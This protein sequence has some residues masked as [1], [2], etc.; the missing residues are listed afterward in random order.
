[1]YEAPLRRASEVAEAWLA[2][3]AN[4]PLRSLGRRGAADLVERCCRL[5]RLAAAGMAR[6][7][8][9][10]ILNDVVLNQVLLR[11]H[12]A[13][14]A[15]VIDRAQRDGTCWLGGT[16]W[17]GEPA[18]RFSVSNWSTTDDDI[19]RSVTAIIRAIGTT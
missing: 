2:S 5:A 15:T 12:G 6:C 13:D 3:A 4:R 7:E 11:V 10:E 17:Q 8:S 18:I 16:S 14:T 19:S 9:I 1:M